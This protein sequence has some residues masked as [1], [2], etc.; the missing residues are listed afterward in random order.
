MTPK[1]TYK[2]GSTPTIGSLYGDY[3]VTILSGMFKYYPTKEWYKSI[4][5]VEGHNIING[6]TTG[7]FD[8]T[9]F[10]SAVEFMY[11]VPKNKKTFWMNMMDF[12]RVTDEQNVLIGKIFIKIF[13]RY[14][15]VGYFSLVK[16]LEEK[17]ED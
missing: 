15:A 8:V 4:N 1:Q 7:H 2:D 14:W 16:R 5:L 3:D 6:K 17:N 12:V 10:E 9:F 11:D 13:G